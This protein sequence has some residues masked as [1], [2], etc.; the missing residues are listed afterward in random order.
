[1]FLT[2]IGVLTKK[3]GEAKLKQLKSD[4]A[5]NNKKNKGKGKRKG[6]EL[7]FVA[8]WETESMLDITDSKREN[9]Q[10]YRWFYDNVLAH[11]KSK[12]A[13]TKTVKTGKAK[14]TE[15]ATVSDEALALLAMENYWKVWEYKNKVARAEKENEEV[16]PEEEMPV[17]LY[18]K[19]NS[20][21]ESWGNGG[22]IRFNEIFDEVTESRIENKEFDEWYKELQKE[23][24]KKT[25][26]DKKKKAPTKDTDEGKVQAKNN[27]VVLVGGDDSGD[28]G[29]GTGSNE[30]EE[31]E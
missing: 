2:L 30:E 23:E 16:D 14:A 29:K 28:K 7:P 22:M 24:Y 13:W 27:L 25:G 8:T 18:T 21:R 17:P 12:K 19:P 4:A 11:T 15:L 20:Q 6:E 31:V 9:R 3:E 10:A 1:M 26:G 5:K